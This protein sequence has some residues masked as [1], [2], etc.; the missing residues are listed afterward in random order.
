MGHAGSKDLDCQILEPLPSDDG[1]L[2]GKTQKV[3]L[4]A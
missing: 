1:D 4:S 3:S 2:A